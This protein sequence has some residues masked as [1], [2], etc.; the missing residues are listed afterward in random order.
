M[1][2]GIKMNNDTTV[3]IILAGLVGV[4]MGVYV[5]RADIE[6]SCMYD[7]RIVFFKDRVF[8]CSYMDGVTIK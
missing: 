5:A 6:E 3:K 2:W 7:N 1:I 8:Q 4:L